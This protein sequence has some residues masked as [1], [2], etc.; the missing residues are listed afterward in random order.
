[1]L[2]LLRNCPSISGHEHRCYFSRSVRSPSLTAAYAPAKKP[3]KLEPIVMI[4][5]GSISDKTP[6]S[7]SRACRT[8]PPNVPPS[9]KTIQT[10]RMRVDCRASFIAAPKGSVPGYTL[11]RDHAC[12]PP[13]GVSSP[14]VWLGRLLG[15]LFRGNRNRPRSSASSSRRQPL[16]ILLL[17]LS[18]GTF[19]PRRWINRH[20][21]YMQNSVR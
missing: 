15:L 21:R 18:T 8:A 4:H 2:N 11:E 20:R 6:M 12:S 19:N 7:T 16:P 10:T 5:G 3:M 17:C 13:A 1:M 14:S 9:Q